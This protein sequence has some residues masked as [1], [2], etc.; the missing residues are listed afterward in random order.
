MNKMEISV[1][2][3]LKQK[4]KRNYGTKEYNNW[5]E[6]SLSGLKGRSEQAEEKNQWT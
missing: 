6:K 3:K 5:N 1:K 4:T 2:R